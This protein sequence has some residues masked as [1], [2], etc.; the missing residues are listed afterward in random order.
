MKAIW[1]D[2]SVEGW[3]RRFCV[4]GGRI[5]LVVENFK[6]KGWAVGLRGRALFRTEDLAKAAAIKAALVEARKMQR[7][8]ASDVDLLTRLEP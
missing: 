6:G 2:L 4:I 5:T 3:E 1:T 7:I 8:L